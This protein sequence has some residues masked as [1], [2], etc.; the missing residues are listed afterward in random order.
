MAL[1]QPLKG[2][3]AFRLW[4]KTW[5]LVFSIDALAA[6]EARLGLTTREISDLFK[7]EFSAATLKTLWWG[8]LQEFHP[9][10]DEKAAGR[11]LSGLG[12]LEANGKLVEAYL[13]TFGR[14]E[15]ASGEADPPPAA[16]SGTG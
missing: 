10:L 9:E 16:A 7:G 14:A 5:T 15:A 1:P 3:V 11:V 13:A 8:A 2:E 12:V 4:D 6:L